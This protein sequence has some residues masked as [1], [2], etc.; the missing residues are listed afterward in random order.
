MACGHDNVVLHKVLS[1]VELAGDTVNDRLGY[2]H[3]MIAITLDKS[4]PAGGNKHPSGNPE[5]T[6]R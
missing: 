3:D 2:L 4:L 6:A 1:G 5:M